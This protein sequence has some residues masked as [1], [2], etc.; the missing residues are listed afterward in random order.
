MCKLSEIMA[1]LGTRKCFATCNPYA[2]PI[3]QAT[4]EKYRFHFCCG[5]YQGVKLS[6]KSNTSS[7]TYIILLPTDHYYVAPLHC[8][9]FCTY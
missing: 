6:P 8:E 9:Y 5:F 3:Y 1:Y 7:T 4:V 2:P